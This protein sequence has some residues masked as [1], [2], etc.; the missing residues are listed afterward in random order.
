MA[1][2]EEHLVY[3]ASLVGCVV[4][5]QSNVEQC[6]WLVQTFIHQSG[7]LDPVSNELY[8]YSAFSSFHPFAA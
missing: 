2:H 3:C 6:A 5:D 1:P 4:A 7:T 8:P